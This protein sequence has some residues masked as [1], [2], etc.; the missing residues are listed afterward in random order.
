MTTDESTAGTDPERA[1]SDPFPTTG[2]HPGG[3]RHDE[4]PFPGV[5]AGVV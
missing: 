4:E 3:P 1:L 5:T 2:E